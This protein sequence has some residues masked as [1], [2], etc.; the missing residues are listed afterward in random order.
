M[1]V[2]FKIVMRTTFYASFYGL[3][4]RLLIALLKASAVYVKATLLPF[5]TLDKRN[6]I[7][8]LFL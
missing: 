7:L 3:P 1:N 5:P 4:R 6:T 2:A 8:I